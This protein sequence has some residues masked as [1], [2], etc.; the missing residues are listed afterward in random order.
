[1]VLH[2]ISAGSQVVMNW[3]LNGI[4]I[5]ESAHKKPTHVYHW[6]YRHTYIIIVLIFNKF[7]SEKQ[8]FS[9]L[10]LS[11]A[12]N[13]KTVGVCV[14]LKRFLLFCRFSFLFFISFSMMI[15][16]SSF[17]YLVLFELLFLFYHLFSNF[18]FRLSNI[19][20]IP[21]KFKNNLT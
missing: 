19:N 12:W 21:C 15:R 10:S 13:Q 2:V 3:N 18:C 4:L 20:S 5:L 14:C 1:M 7:I 16:I 17:F 6:S 8:K 9:F 11:Y